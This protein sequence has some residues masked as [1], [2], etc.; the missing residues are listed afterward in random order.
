MELLFDNILLI[1]A[2]P[3]D[4]EIGTMCFFFFFFSFFHLRRQSQTL[5][6]VFRRLITVS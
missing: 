2:V 1:K 4:N 6:V 3:M 5:L